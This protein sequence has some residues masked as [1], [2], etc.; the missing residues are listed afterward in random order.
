M[1][2]SWERF[3]DAPSCQKEYHDGAARAGF[4]RGRRGLAS[5]GSGRCIAGQW[6]GGYQGE[7]SMARIEA[8]LLIKKLNTACM[9]ALETPVGTCMS[10]THYEVTIDPY[11]A[12]LMARPDSDGA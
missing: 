12:T 7:T 9:R 2:V 6:A 1:T 10:R 5:S 11:L 4:Q 3:A 8:K